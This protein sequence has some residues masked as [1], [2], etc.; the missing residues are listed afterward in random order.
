MRQAHRLI[1]HAYKAVLMK[2]TKALL[3]AH[4]VLLAFP[5]LQLVFHYIKKKELKK[6]GFSLSVG[7]VDYCGCFLFVEINYPTHQNKLSSPS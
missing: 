2:Y 3:V 7:M 6:K 4:E 5:K 1:I